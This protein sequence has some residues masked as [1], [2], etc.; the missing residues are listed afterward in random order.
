MNL[1]ELLASTSK[2]ESTTTGKVKPVGSINVLIGDVVVF[3]RP[4][5][6]ESTSETQLLNELNDLCIN[7]KTKATEIFKLLL[8]KM[9]VEVNVRGSSELTLADL[10]K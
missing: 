3:N 6:K 1:A 5:W 9:T 2:T 7:D 4:V 8:S 10:L